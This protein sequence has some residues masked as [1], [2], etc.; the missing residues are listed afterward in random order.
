[1]TKTVRSAIVP[2]VVL[3]AA[4]TACAHR[5]SDAGVRR[6]QL[7]GTV[8]SHDTS[9]S[10][11]VVNH[12]PVTGLMPAM[13]M[14]FELRGVAP[15]MRGGD[16]VAAALVMTDNRSWLEDVRITAAGGRRGSGQS[17]AARAMPG[18]IVPELR[19]VDQDGEA[20]ALRDLAGKAV[21]LTFIYTRC[22]LP[23]FCPLMVKRLESVRR[24][25]NEA[26]LGDRVALLGVTLDPAFD[27]PI[28]LRTYGES[29][30]KGADRFDQWT[31]ATGSA[32]QVEAV[33]QFFGV[34]F[35][36]ENGLITHALTTAVVGHDGRVMRLFESNSWHPDELFDVARRVAERAAASADDT[37]QGR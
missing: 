19:L 25:A 9:S 6:F 37:A 13:T 26:G 1:M 32:E 30:L 35:R 22:P 21:V 7:T 24:R 36:G 27:T 2:T 23:D 15:A 12:E 4:T 33:T 31:L 20:F 14:S 29:V 10:R 8:V 5:D 18:A 3:L 11:V 17:N 28:V 16:R 34:G